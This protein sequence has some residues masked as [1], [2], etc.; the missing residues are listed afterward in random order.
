MAKKPT[1]TIWAIL[2]RKNSKDYWVQIGAGWE[3]QDGSI[4]ERR[5]LNPVDPNVTVQVR[6][7][8][9]RPAEADATHED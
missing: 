7:R 2:P 6:R 1:H 4:N 5:E 3:N 8:E 9:D